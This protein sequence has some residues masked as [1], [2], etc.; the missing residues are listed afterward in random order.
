MT[1]DEPVLHDPERLIALS[2]AARDRRAGL[3]ALWQLDE[4]LAGVLRTT[5]EP[6]VGQMRLTWWH[7]ALSAMDDG[8]VPNQPLLSALAGAVLPRGISGQTMA[9]MVDGW[10]ALLDAEPLDEAAL[11][12]HAEAR[13]AGLFRLGAQ[14]LGGT[15]D[16]AVVQAGIGWALVDLGWHVRDSAARRQCLSLAG[17][18]LEGALASRWPRLI[19]PLGMLARLALIDARVDTLTV[20]QQGSPARLLRMMGYAISGR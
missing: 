16:G 2:Y 1:S 3:A 5:R 14:L 20:R 9:G 4:T 17:P 19:R 15:D 7:A 13:G 8:I 6:M 11:M 18:V 12:A 10:E